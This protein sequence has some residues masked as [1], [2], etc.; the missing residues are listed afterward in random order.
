MKWNLIRSNFES[1]FL[2]FVPDIFLSKW[3]LLFLRLIMSLACLDNVSSWYT[4]CCFIRWTYFSTFSPGRFHH[5][6][7]NIFNQDCPTDLN[8]TANMYVAVQNSAENH[9]QV[10]C[11][12]IESWRTI[13]A[14]GY[15]FMCLHDLR[16]IDCCWSQFWKLLELNSTTDMS[17]Q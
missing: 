4:N 14:F 15:Q 17:L 9:F 10:G 7:D 8:K 12:R 11:S 1:S 2:N 5:P 16:K 6:R 3:F 13:L